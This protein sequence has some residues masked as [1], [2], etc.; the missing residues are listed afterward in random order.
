[1]VFGGGI[2]NKRVWRVCLNFH[3]HRWEEAVDVVYCGCPTHGFQTYGAGDYSDQEFCS[4]KGGVIPFLNLKARAGNGFLF[5]QLF[6]SEMNIWSEISF[7]L[8]IC[9]RRS[10]EE[11]FI[12]LE[13]KLLWIL[14]SAENVFFLLNSEIKMAWL[15]LFAKS[16]F[17][18]SQPKGTTWYFQVSIRD[19]FPSAGVGSNNRPYGTLVF[20]RWR[21]IE[22][23]ITYVKSIFML[24]PISTVITMGGDSS[25]CQPSPLHWQ[26]KQQHR[27]K[28]PCTFGHFKWQDEA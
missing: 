3:H 18:L 28:Y 21:R 16:I 1:M 27:Y 23:G 5:H 22:S 24:I 13:N 12:P 7:Q 11:Y 25:S 19:A 9:Y 26:N 6:H 4:V 10:K 20:A 14:L 17:S 8:E 2:E 15:F